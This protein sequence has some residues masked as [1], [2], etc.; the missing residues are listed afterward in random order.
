MCLAGVLDHHQAVFTGYVEDGIHIGHLP[1][2]MHGHHGSDGPAA[3]QAD[4]CAALVANALLLEIA[5]QHNG[6]HIV[7]ALVDIDEL[8]KSAC[9]R[10]RFSGGDEGVGDGEHDIARLHAAGHDGEA[11]RICAAAD[12]D[13]KV[14]LAQ[15]S[16]GLLKFFDDRAANETCS[17]QALTESGR[18]L[19]FKFE[20]RRDQVEKWNRRVGDRFRLFDEAK[21][22][23]W[24]SGNNRIRRNIF[25]DDAACADDRVFADHDVRQDRGAGTN[26]RALPDQGALDAPVGL[27]L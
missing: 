7:G 3:P 17:P 5:L 9:L 20:M 12:G 11:E 16:K 14:S 13:A 10:D 1:V 24:V 26:G 6:R 22:L 25:G 4:E 15:G 21:H 19:L 8:R 18:E 23:R 2:E 27:R